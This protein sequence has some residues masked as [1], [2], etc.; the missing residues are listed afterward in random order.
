MEVFRDQAIL[1]ATGLQA[2]RRMRFIWRLSAVRASPIRKRRVREA[3]PGVDI[4]ALDQAWSEG[5]SRPRWRM[6]CQR[7][8]AHGDDLTLDAL[9]GRGV[10]MAVVIDDAD[11]AGVQVIWQRRGCC[12]SSKPTSDRIGPCPGTE[13]GQT[14]PYLAGADVRR[15]ASRPLCRVRRQRYRHGLPPQVRSPGVS[16]MANTRNTSPASRTDPFPNLVSAMRRRWAKPYG[17]RGFW[18]EAQRGRKW[19]GRDCNSSL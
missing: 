17:W 3:V 16:D 6:R 2:R 18:T 12:P 1:R 7:L 4:E 13:A 14:A 11:G 10:P 5:A 15:P 19:I 8:V 9:A